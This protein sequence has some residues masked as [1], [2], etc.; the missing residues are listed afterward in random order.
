MW[1]KQDLNKMKRKKILIIGG[2]LDFSRECERL[3]K[4][5]SLRM[6]II[7]ERFKVVYPYCD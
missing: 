4:D 5:P 2:G 1:C 6:P 3:G 7:C